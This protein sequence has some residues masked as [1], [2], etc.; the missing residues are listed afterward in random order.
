MC[1]W[2]LQTGKTEARLEHNESKMSKAANGKYYQVIES[3]LERESL[4]VI[5]YHYNFSWEF[6]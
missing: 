5:L 4:E 1:E 6:R 2:I 3:D